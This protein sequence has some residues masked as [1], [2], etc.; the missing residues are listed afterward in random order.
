EYT[1]DLST[2]LRGEAVK[3]VSKGLLLGAYKLEI[4]SDGKLKKKGAVK[5][6]ISDKIAWPFKGPKTPVDLSVSTDDA[7]EL[8]LEGTKDYEADFPGLSKTTFTFADK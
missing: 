3:K 7:H 2:L 5:G 6:E 8:K 1:G 4:G